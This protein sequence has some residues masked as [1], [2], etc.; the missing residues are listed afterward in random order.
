MVLAEE[1]LGLER[2][3]KWVFISCPPL[4]FGGDSPAPA[5]ALLNVN[6]H[7]HTLHERH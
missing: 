3:D 1:L 2:L 7:F 4:F 6:I 5:E